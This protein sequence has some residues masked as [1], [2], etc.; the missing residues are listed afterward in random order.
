MDTYWEVLAELNNG[1]NETLGVYDLPD[2]AI[3]DARKAVATQRWSM[4]K[5]IHVVKCETILTLT[6]D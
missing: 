5:A 2:N 1:C 6:E 4:T 3:S